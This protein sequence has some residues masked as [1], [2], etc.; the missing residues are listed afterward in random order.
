MFKARVL[1]ILFFLFTLTSSL[2]AAAKNP[3][4]VIKRWLID[5]TDNKDK[6]IGF[7]NV[8]VLAPETDYPKLIEFYYVRPDEDYDMD[9]EDI[10]TFK[11]GQGSSLKGSY[12]ANEFKIN[13]KKTSFFKKDSLG[14]QKVK[15]EFR[16]I[17]EFP[18]SIIIRN[19][20]EAELLTTKGK[21]SLK[22]VDVQQLDP[23]Y[24]QTIEDP[25]FSLNI[26]FP[27]VRSNEIKPGKKRE[28]MIKDFLETFRLYS[29]L[30]FKALK[31]VIKPTLPVDGHSQCDDLLLKPIGSK[32]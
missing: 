24:F 14:R 8:G 31:R 16:R 4:E 1:L 11:V 9:F 10:H 5:I 32:D 17:S 6:F 26:R 3:R 20:G 12:S 19:S 30:N 18:V 15:K 22:T 13:I 27:D 23:E 28:E 21:Y 25:E 2:H 29:D 7:I